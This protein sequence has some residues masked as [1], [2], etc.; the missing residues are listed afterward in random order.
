VKY[1]ITDEET[2][3][4]VWGTIVHEVLNQG[5]VL[6]VK[7]DYQQKAVRTN[8]LCA[9]LSKMCPNFAAKHSWDKMGLSVK[10]DE[11]DG[12]TMFKV[13]LCKENRWAKMVFPILLLLLLLALIGVFCVS[14]CGNTQSKIGVWGPCAVTIGHE[15]ITVKPLNP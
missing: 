13:L 3:K 9:L 15:S 5:F 8:I 4:K 6:G 10:M 1:T 11:G 7:F 12:I 2:V 14:S